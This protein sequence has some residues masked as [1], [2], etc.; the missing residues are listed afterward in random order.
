MKK[1]IIGLLIILICFF[2]FTMNKTFNSIDDLAYVIGLGIDVGSS[3]NLKVSFQIA[4]PSVAESSSSGSS[5]KKYT[6]STVEASSINAAKALV[7]SYTS[8]EL[9]LSHCKVIVISE[10]YASQG[11]S[12]ILYTLT[13]DIETRPDCNLMISSCD[14]KSILENSTPS[15]ESLPSKYYEVTSNSSQYTGYATDT[16]KTEFLSS[17]SKTFQ[18]PYAILC[19]VNTSSSSNSSSN[20]QENSIEKDTTVTAGSIKIKSDQSGIVINGTSVFYEDKLVGELNS[21]E[22][23]CH[24]IITNDLKDCVISIKNP[25]DE[26]GTMD[27][28][29]TINKSTKTDVDL[30]NGSPYV[31]AKINLKAYILSMSDNSDYTSEENFKIIEEYVNSYL[32]SEI[33]AYFY[34]TAKEYKSDI[35]GL[36]KKVVGKFLTWKEWKNYNWLS[37][38]QN[39]FFNIDV[40]TNVKSGYLL[41][42]S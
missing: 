17:L 12:D 15:L 28:S 7:N 21:I 40:T 6:I 38:Y 14:A 24:L 37:N 8:K 25:F 23:L 3:N 22:T 20:S 19:D 41:L 18:Q 26:N 36:G 1:I 30:I 32:E 9:N 35:A 31:H 13:N 10:T 29:V 42:K 27:L 4:I 33:S 16:Y 34:K 2:A 5:D 39:S 11:I